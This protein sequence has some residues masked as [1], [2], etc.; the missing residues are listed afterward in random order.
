MKKSFFRHLFGKNETQNYLGDGSAEAA[1]KESKSTLRQILDTVIYLAACLLIFGGIASLIWILRPY[2]VLYMMPS[3][4]AN[5]EKKIESGKISDNR[6]IIP[7]VLVDAPIV[8]GVS[9]K[10]LTQGVAHVSDSSFPGESGNCILEGHNYAEFGLFKPMSF[11]SLLELIN[12][13]ARVYIFHKGKK[14]IYRVSRKKKLDI[15]SSN[16]YKKTDNEQLT[17]ITCVST[18]SVNIYTNKRTVVTCL[19]I[20]PRQ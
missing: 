3:A 2:F 17:L 1:K 16:L 14:N 10:S 5:L 11:F 7:S 15:S 4:R 6:I 9:G 8:E 13:D 18:W 12:K 20:K 19:P